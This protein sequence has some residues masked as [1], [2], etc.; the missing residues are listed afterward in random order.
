MPTAP[1]QCLRAIIPAFPVC[2]EEITDP[3]ANERVNFSCSP[4]RFVAH[5]L[6]GAREDGLGILNISRDCKML[7][8]M[9]QVLT[10]T[11]AGVQAPGR[12]NSVTLQID[13]TRGVWL[14]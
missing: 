10:F 3:R 1:A 6:D 8:L 4:S 7:S 14:A 5:R 11:R 12:L 13:S 9:F 2:D